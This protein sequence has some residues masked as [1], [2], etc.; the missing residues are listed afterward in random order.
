MIKMN[1]GLDVR[2]KE[3]DEEGDFELEFM[4]PGAK[5]P[6]KRWFKDMESAL[7][8]ASFVA[9]QSGINTPETLYPW[10]EARGLPGRDPVA[11]GPQV[12]ILEESDEESS[13][14][15]E[16]S[17]GVDVVS[18]SKLAPLVDDV[19]KQKAE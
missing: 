19:E 4:L 1:C 6:T 3:R 2:F 13:D 10:L 17:G 9:A 8:M 7:R 16:I 15:E 5:E 12:E 14:R 18:D 11:D